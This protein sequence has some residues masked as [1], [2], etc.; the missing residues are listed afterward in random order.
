VRLNLN[1]N[2]TP[3]CPSRTDFGI[4]AVGAGFIMR[5]VQLK[6]YADAGFNAVAITSRT[7]EIAREVADLRA[8]PKVYDNLGEMLSDPD[9]EILDIAVPPG[10]QLAI[11][12]EATERGKYLKGILAQKPLAVDYENA[13][14]IVECCSRH[15]IPLVVNQNMRYDQ[16]IRALKTILDRGYLGSPVL[17]TIEMRAVPHWQSWLP[18]YGRLT[19]LNMSVHHLDAFRYLFGN[20]ESIFVSA[21]KDPRTRFPHED[22]ICLYILEYSDGLRATAW[23]D[24]WAGP[25]T[26]QDSFDPYIKWR[27]E[28]TEGLAEGTIGWPNYPNRTPSTLRFTS[29]LEPNVWLVPKWSEVWFPDAFQ[30]PMCELME[31]I[32]T[33]VPPPTSGADNLHTMALIEAGYRSLRERRLVSLSEINQPSSITSASR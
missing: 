23:D 10:S 15:G 8:V 21:R 3:S 17:A 32:A 13:A 14:Q 6:A 5:D 27:V 26:D 18:N 31:A 22:G 20:P 28:G 11:V 19:L 29:S 30:G 2:Q 7:P 4:G 33:G 16:S 24:V 25:R 1:L 9:V 12:R